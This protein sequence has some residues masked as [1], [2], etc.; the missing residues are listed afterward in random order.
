VLVELLLISQRE[1]R[2]RVVRRVEQNPTNLAE[3]SASGI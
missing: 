1:L 3:A 2:I